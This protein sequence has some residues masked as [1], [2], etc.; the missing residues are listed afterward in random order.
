MNGL[1]SLDDF[2]I[3]GKSTGKRWASG[4]ANANSNGGLSIDL[5]FTANLIIFYSSTAKYIAFSN[6]SS[7]TIYGI[8]MNG[9]WTNEI[10]IASNGFSINNG[11]FSA[12]TQVS[13][14]AFE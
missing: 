5:T 4:T 10:T 7:T 6:F 12:E 3:Q 14:Y 11:F 1:K 13:W 8:G 2:L 9:S